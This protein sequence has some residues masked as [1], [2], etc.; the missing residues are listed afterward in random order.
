VRLPGGKGVTPRVYYRRV[1][2]AEAY[3][4]QQMD[5]GGGGDEYRATIP[6]QYTDSPFPLEYYFELRDGAGRAWMF[7]GFNPDW[8]NQPYFVIRQSRSG[9]AAR[10]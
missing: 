1:N 6:A 3:V 5:G 4:A 2:Q 8:S 7:P 10:S 9:A